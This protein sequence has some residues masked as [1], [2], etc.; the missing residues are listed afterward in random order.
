MRTDTLRSLGVAAAAIGLML[1]SLPT[2]AARLVMPQVS[3]HVTSITGNISITVEGKQ[4]MIAAGSTAATS[5]RDVHIGD[6]VGLVMDGPANK[7]GTHV[8][9]IQKQSTP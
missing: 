7:S 3:G 8:I 4:Y 5:V 6:E 1:C 9:A 2:I